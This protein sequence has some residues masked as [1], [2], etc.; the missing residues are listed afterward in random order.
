MPDVR[1]QREPPAAWPVLLLAGVAV[2]VLATMAWAMLAPAARHGERLDPVVGVP[3]IAVLLVASGIGGWALTAAPRRLEYRLRGRA[4]QIATLL[5]RR[6]VPLSR[7]VSAEVVDFRLTTM[8][9]AHAGFLNSHMPG[10]YVGLFPLSGL[11]RTRVVVGV[12]QGR[13]VLLRFAEEDPLLLAPRDPQALV[14]LVQ[15]RSGRRAGPL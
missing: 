6:V 10:Y 15:E 1:P 13:G 5:G 14:E 9:G 8:P 2:V 4:L 7:V 3:V 12:R 11:G